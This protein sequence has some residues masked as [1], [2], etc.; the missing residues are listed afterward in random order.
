[1]MQRLAGA[2]AMRLGM[3]FAVV[4]VSGLLASA[5]T[6]QVSNRART[7]CAG[8]EAGHSAATRVAGC[9]ALI[10]DGNASSSALAMA[11]SLRG[12]ALAEQYQFASA[13]A[14]FSEVILLEPNN[15]IAL[16]NRGIAY[17]RLKQFS[18][19]LADFNQVV[20]L[21]PKNPYIYNDRGNAYDD[22]EQYVLAIADYDRAIRL[23]ANNAEAFANRG[24][25]YGHE[26]QYARAI[27]DYN[28][29]I[30]LRPNYALAFQN[31]GVAKSKLGLDGSA[32]D[33]ARAKA[34]NSK[35]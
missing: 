26:K 34:I 24:L 33:M 21:V 10:N 9:T 22:L 12:E 3:Y 8:I 28:E 16:H 6:A 32:A 4:A 17:G 5:G 7:A 30:R 2:S 19:A 31:R 25:A 13:I 1:M 15:V 29:A 20:R 18:K 23:Q 14:D 35:F 27:V 11:H